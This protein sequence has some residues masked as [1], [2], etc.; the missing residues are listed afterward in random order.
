MTIGFRT[1]SFKTGTLLKSG[2]YEVL[3][4]QGKSCELDERE[5]ENQSVIWLDS[6]IHTLKNQGGS[7]VIRWHF[8]NEQIEQLIRS[9]PNKYPYLIS[10]K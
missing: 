6:G 5:V 8:K 3:N 4:S 1:E 2:F 10:P 9:N 7:T